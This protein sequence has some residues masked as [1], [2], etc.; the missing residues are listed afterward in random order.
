MRPMGVD[1]YIFVQVE[2]GTPPEVAV[3]FMEIE[4]IKT[5]HAVTGQY[6]I[7]VFAHL[8][9]LNSLNNLLKRIHLMAGVRH[10]QTAICIPQTERSK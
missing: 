4:Q 7:I 9:A 1:V 3:E 10:T 5:A 8:D 2:K 6:D